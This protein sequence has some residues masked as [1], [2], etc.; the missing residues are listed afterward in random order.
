MQPARASIASFAA[1][2]LDKPQAQQCGQ[3]EHLAGR[4]WRLGHGIDGLTALL[5]VADLPQVATDHRAELELA[6]RSERDL[7]RRDRLRVLTVGWT[8]PHAA[9]RVLALDRPGPPVTD[10]VAT[11]EVV[12]ARRL[13]TVLDAVLAVRL[14][15]TG[16]RV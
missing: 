15:T 16:H 14:A 4:R 3:R 12:L 2:P 1:L 9:L 13:R 6:A 5:V 8:A 11:L 7:A 10:R